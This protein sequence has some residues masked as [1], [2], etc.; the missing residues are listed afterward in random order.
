MTKRMEIAS[1]LTGI[2]QAK[3]L[4][5]ELVQTMVKNQISQAVSLDI[6]LSNNELILDF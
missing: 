1:Y 6:I 2:G 5:I 4:Q 3:S